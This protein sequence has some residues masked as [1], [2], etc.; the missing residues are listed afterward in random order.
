M[1]FLFLRL[2]TPEDN[3]EAF[4]Y[5]RGDTFQILG[6]QNKEKEYLLAYSDEE[7]LLTLINLF[8]NKK[9][10]VKLYCIRNCYSDCFKMRF[11]SMC[12]NEIQDFVKNETPR[13]IYYEENDTVTFLQIL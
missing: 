3:Q 4:L 5:K 6:F 8:F 10:E 13:E 7:K 12:Y 1:S 2:F 9:F 11:H